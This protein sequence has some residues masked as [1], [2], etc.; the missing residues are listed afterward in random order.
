MWNRFWS[1]VSKIALHIFVSMIPKNYVGVIG[2]T[3]KI[4]AD[5]IMHVAQ[6]K[7]DGCGFCLAQFTVWS[8][9]KANYKL[10]KPAGRIGQGRFILHG[11]AHPS[12]N[13]LRAG[14]HG[15][16]FLKSLDDIF[17]RSVTPR[18]LFTIDRME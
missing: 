12:C 13:R 1:Q 4:S 6:V 3:V 2:N 10:A 17:K 18:W 8:D 15:D 9:R 7:G 5:K 14:S 16:F 11:Q